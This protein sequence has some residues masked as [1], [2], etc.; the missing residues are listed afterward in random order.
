MYK[1]LGTIDYFGISFDV[2]N[3]NNSYL[4]INKKLKIFKR[5]DLQ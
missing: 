5:I 3:Y 2:Y 1:Y 4:Y